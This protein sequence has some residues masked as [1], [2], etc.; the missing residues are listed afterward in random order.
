MRRRALRSTTDCG[1]ASQ[2][3][4]PARRSLRALFCNTRSRI[5]RPKPSGL[6][7]RISMP[8]PFLLWPRLFEVAFTT[9]LVAV[10]TA[11]FFTDESEVMEPPVA[12]VERTAVLLFL[13]RSNPH[14]R[15]TAAHCSA[16]RLNHPQ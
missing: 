2:S 8:C 16:N 15:A 11:V 12:D 5:L 10:E 4:S 7:E 1:T 14:A 13:H 3:R 6:R 9:N